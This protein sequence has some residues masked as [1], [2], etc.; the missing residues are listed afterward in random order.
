[1]TKEAIANGLGDIPS[2][3]VS[4]LS[5]YFRMVAECLPS[6]PQWPYIRFVAAF[7]HRG[8]QEGRLVPLA[9]FQ[10]KAE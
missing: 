4:K 5:Q 8:P 6:S 7:C 10:R 1:M 9:V 2:L 3:N